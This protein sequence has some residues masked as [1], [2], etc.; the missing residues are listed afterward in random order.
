MATP[1]T[2]VLARFRLAS[3][4]RLG[5]DAETKKWTLQPLEN[6]VVEVNQAG[7]TVCLV[8]HDPDYAAMA[9]R[10]IYLVDGKLLLRSPSAVH[11]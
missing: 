10:E 6:L 5:A 9:G 1:L 7:T 3:P 8:T 4:L 11:R 2:R